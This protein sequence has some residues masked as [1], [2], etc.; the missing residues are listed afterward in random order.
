MARSSKRGRRT[1]ESPQQLSQNLVAAVN[2]GDLAWASACFS[3]QACLVTPGDTVVR[4][5]EAIEPVL[6]QLIAAATEIQVERL[7]MLDTPEFAL[8]Y[9]CWTFRSAADAARS[10]SHAPTATLGMRRLEE[11]WKLEIAALWGWPRALPGRS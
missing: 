1:A 6:W 3:R 2:G 9:E 8:S 4:G 5:R 11:G 10:F 7:G